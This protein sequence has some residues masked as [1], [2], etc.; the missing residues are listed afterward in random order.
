MSNV[1]VIVPHADDET[2]GFGG[3]IQYH[4]AQ[5]DTVSVIICRKPHDERTQQQINDS[6]VALNILGVKNVFFLNVTEVE[7]SNTP[8]KLF[9]DLEA[10][11]QHIRPAVIYTT[12]WGDNHQ[13]HKILFDCVARAA[14]IHGPLCVKRLLV[15]EIPSS[16][17]QS[18]KT[19]SN[20]F[21][22]NTY[23]RITYE[24]L[25]NKITAME[26]YTTESR[27]SPHPRS[28]DY[29]ACLARTRGIESGS[30]YAEAFMLVR[31]IL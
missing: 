11:L 10:Q 27:Q 12:F 4:I 14:R 25:H 31:D 2:L 15:G 30:K 8:L 29:L 3:A 26:A 18:P 24:Q 22:P 20:M 28:A 21:T 19:P 23:I 16:T 9:R 6:K 13:D 5:N 1:C 17:D 7:I